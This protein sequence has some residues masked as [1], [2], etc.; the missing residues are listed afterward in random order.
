MQEFTVFDMVIVAITLLLSLKGLFRGFIKE[1]F[2]LVG[3]I[4]G[5]FVASRMALD[6]GN[7]I[8]PVLSIEN[9]ATIKLIG[10]ILGVVGFWFII[11]IA[12]IILSKIFSMS[13]LGFFDRVLGFLFGGAKIFLIFSVIAYALYQISAFKSLMD[14]KVSNSITFPFLVKTGSFIIKLDPA[15]FMNKITPEDKNGVSQKVNNAVDELK[16]AAQESKDAVVDTVKETVNENVEKM[17]DDITKDST[18]E[19][20][21]QEQP[22]KTETKQ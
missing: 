3:I 18:V 8:A 19:E 5:I 16:Q 4:G 11:Y 9:T 6:I 13:G 14:E 22:I 21:T 20:K 17:A 1:V 10:F 2:G 12:G 15:D 7:L